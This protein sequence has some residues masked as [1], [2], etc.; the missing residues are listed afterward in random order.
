MVVTNDIMN[1]RREKTCFAVTAERKYFHA[2]NSFVKRSLRPSE[3]QVSRWKGTIHVPRM[4]N[5]RLLNEAAALEYIHQHTNIPVPKLYSCFED[6]QAVVLVT[7]YVEGVGMND[8]TDAQRTTVKAELDQHLQ[9]LQ[10]LRS[11]R[12]GGPSGIVIPPLPRHRSHPARRLVRPPGS[13]EPA[14]IRLLP[15]RPLAAERGRGPGVA[16]NPSDIGLGVRGVLAR[17]V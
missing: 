12:L 14:R 1:Q 13:L 15:Q 3:W 9:T 6:D 10:T 4:G 17:V 11:A 8:L 5:E 2:G 16:E 7:E